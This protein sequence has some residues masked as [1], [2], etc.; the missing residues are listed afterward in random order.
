VAATT[1]ER[2]ARL[3]VDPAFGPFDFELR[4]LCAQAG[5]APAARRGAAELAR[6]LYQAFLRADAS[7][8]EINPLVLT[9]RGELVA[10][11]AK[12]E[13]DD[14]ALYRQPALA[15]YKEASEED[16]IEAEAHR[17][18]VN[19]V[20]L[21]GD[22]GIIGN[23]AGLVMSTLD[24]V[25]RHGGR[26]ANFLDIGG[27]ARAEVVRQALSIVLMDPNV[28]GVL[29]NIFGGITRGDDVARGILE[30]VRTMDVR[31]PMV[32]RMAGTRAEEGLKLL[33]GS[34]LIPAATPDEAARR[35][36]ELVAAR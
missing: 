21:Q 11:D 28:K 22:I 25:T 18:G 9:E 24:L 13:V 30:A 33:E 5:F 1:P 20:R 26:P 23:G 32:V 6:R 17:R 35:I 16:P 4:A 29:F 34:P 8:A 36:I 19:Y 31:V 2:I 27:G 3:E 10:A 7:L 12:F 14:N 15:A